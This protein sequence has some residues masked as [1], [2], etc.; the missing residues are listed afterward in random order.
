MNDGRARHAKLAVELHGGWQVEFEREVAHTLACH[1]SHAEVRSPQRGC[2]QARALDHVT[3]G[4]KADIEF[5]IRNCGVRSDVKCATQVLAIR[6]R[7]HQRLSSAGGN[8]AICAYGNPFISQELFERRVDVDGISF[9]PRDA[10]AC[11]QHGG[12][13]PKPAAVEEGASVDRANVD[14]GGRLLVDQVGDLF[15]G[16][17]VNAQRFCEIISGARGDDGEAAP[18]LRADDGVGDL[19]A[20]TVASNSNED[21]GAAGNRAL[22]ED[23]FFARGSS[24]VQSG[25]AAARKRVANPR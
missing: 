10:V 23:R 12:V 14:K 20:S 7:D 22:C 16:V 2:E 25:D 5:S 9:E 13:E 19:A 24:F 17:V 4:E 6:D 18:G 11:L 3:V 21:S 15:G 8:D 1:R